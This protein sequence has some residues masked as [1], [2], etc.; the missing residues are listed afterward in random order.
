MLLAIQKSVAIFVLM[1]LTQFA[2][3][4]EDNGDPW[5]RWN[6][7]VYTFNRTLDQKVL[8]PITQTYLSVTPKLVQAGTANFLSNIADVPTMINN[9]LQGKIQRSASD[10][11]R[12][13]LN[14]TLGFAGLWDVA[15]SLGLKKHSED[16]GQT[17]G[18][19]G[20]PTGPYMMLPLFGPKTLRG[21]SDYAAYPKY[22]VL[23]TVDHLPTRALLNG[24]TVITARGE[25]IKFED[26]LR[27]S[28]DEYVL[29]REMY[30][31]NRQHSVFD[32]RV[33]VEIDTCDD[34]FD[35]SCEF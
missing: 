5:E 20:V 14:S 7:K 25:F 8:L 26:L 21:L 10:L 4:I 24:L 1:V 28:P 27:R 9:I 33:P 3:A 16:F 34:E 32:G 2:N 19:W 6:R 15:S 18:F 31:Q 23:K 22:D 35:V 17:L 30:L 29:I 12:I 13:A 11:G